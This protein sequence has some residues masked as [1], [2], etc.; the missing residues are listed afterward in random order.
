MSSGAKRMIWIGPEGKSAFVC[1]VGIFVDCSAYTHQIGAAFCEQRFCLRKC[2]NPSGQKDGNVDCLFHR[3]GQVPEIPGFAV[4]RTHIAIHAAGEVQQI[5][6]ALFKNPAGFHTICNRTASD[7][8]VTAAQPY[9]DGK[10]GANRIPNG[11][12]NFQVESGAGFHR[13]GTVCVRSL[14]GK[15]EKNWL[16]R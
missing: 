6:T 1:P 14:V 16:S 2:C 5:H 15:G 9:G 13:L 3:N 7:R 12:N 10:C 4:A 11:L 8:I